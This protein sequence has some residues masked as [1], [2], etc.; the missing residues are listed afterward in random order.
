MTL[1]TKAGASKN[2]YCDHNVMNAKIR[3]HAVQLFL[4]ISLAVVS[5]VAQLPA[6]GP[7]PV[8]DRQSPPLI[9]PQPPS[10]G[11]FNGSGT[12]DK[13]VPGVIQ[14]TLL[15]AI[16]RGIKHNLGL[17]LSQQQ[18]AFARAQYRSQLS[19][20]LPNVS[21]NVSDSINQ[22][23]LAAFG[24]P[25]P[26]G[27]TSPVVGPFGIF[28]AHANMAETLWDFNAINKVHAASQ[29]EKAAK[30]DVQDAR[31]L[32]VLV[33]GNEYLLT[34]A[35]AARL[36]TAKAQFNT[37]QTIFRQSQDLKAAG[38]NAGIDVLRAQ[39]QMQ[40]QQQRVLA[41]QNQY[42]QQKMVFARTIGIPVSQQFQLTDNV[43]YAQ[44]PPLNLD[45]AIAQAYKQRPEFLA[46]EARTRASELTVKAARGE[47]LPSLE[48]N[49][50]AGYIG[51]S[52]GS[53][54]FTYNLTAGVRIPVF[55]GGRV[56]A[57]VDQAESQLRQN[58]LQLED[59]RSRVEMEVRSAWLDV[60]TSDDQV[61]VSRQ[62]VDLA[63]Q[64]LKESQDRYAAG[65]SGSLEVVQSQEAV[66]TANDSYIQ[67]LYQNNVAKLTLAR[68]LG[69]AEQRTR[70]FLGGK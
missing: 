70:A 65:V 34:I 29:N 62:Q 24:I 37:A 13:L 11:A 57:D 40:T 9:T 16:D 55:Q 22:I 36:D 15:D 18:S 1:T 45:E 6:S 20:L 5:A 38:V 46:A 47:S 52:P 49:G 21:G 26:A 43:P 27:L 25:L 56:R 31:E 61:A 67:A 39:V 3:T 12:V 8:P 59:L 17:L 23:N 58:R 50:Q 41:A 44:L 4:F 64:Q 19:A 63:G 54:E 42:E 48:L 30:F 7:A 60:K 33:V 66:A 10:A 53:A 28:D 14:I 51:P 68:A 32:V 69:E 35:S 2:R